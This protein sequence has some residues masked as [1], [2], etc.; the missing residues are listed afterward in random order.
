VQDTAAVQLFVD[1]A[2]AARSNFTLSE[3]ELAAVAEICRRLDGLPLAI[4]LAAARV[5]LL[6]PGEIL[7]LDE[8]NTALS[9]MIKSNL[10][11][12]GPDERELFARLSVFSRGFTL[13]AAQHV[14]EPRTL[15]QPLVDLLDNLAR[16]SLVQ[17]PATETGT[18]TRFSMLE[19]VRQIAFD[20]LRGTGEAETYQRRQADYF[21][22]LVAEADA[23]LMGSAQARALEQLRLERNNIRAALRRQRRHAR[24]GGGPRDRQ[25]AVALLAV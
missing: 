1:R 4:E 25:S 7:R 11:L 6:R 3:P 22:H 12:L 24:A 17:R 23:G 19:A 15:N 9:S 10:A 21:L 20:A 16:S 14:C 2:R 13:H 18:E 8:G 5:R